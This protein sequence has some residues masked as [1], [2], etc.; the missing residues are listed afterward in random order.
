MAGKAFV[1]L[2]GYKTSELQ[3]LPDLFFRDAARN[4][5]TDPQILFRIP[6]DKKHCPSGLQDAV[7]LLEEVQAASYLMVDV[8][9]IDEVDG[10]ILDGDPVADALLDPDIGKVEVLDPL[11]EFF[12]GRGAPVNGDDP[13]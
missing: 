9:Q 10:G 8:A 13:P 1:L 3:I 12:Q 11:V 2:K 6:I 5:R 4:R 7:D